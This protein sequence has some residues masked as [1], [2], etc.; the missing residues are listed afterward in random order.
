MKAKYQE[1][2]KHALD[3]IPLMGLLSNGKL[4]NEYKGYISSFGTAIGQSGALPAILFFSE[5]AKDGADKTDTKYRRCLLMKA[6]YAIL[7]IDKFIDKNDAA[8]AI[9]QEKLNGLSQSKASVLL[10][11]ITNTDANNPQ[12]YKSRKETLKILDAALALKMAMRA[13]ESDTTNA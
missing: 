9:N 10:N 2:I 11:Y 7:N 6:I 1:N 5:K 12:K 3:I 4:P 8:V 13:F